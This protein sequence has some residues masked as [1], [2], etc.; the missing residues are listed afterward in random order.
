MLYYILQAALDLECNESHN[1][2]FFFFGLLWKL[3]FEI[4]NQ[5]LHADATSSLCELLSVYP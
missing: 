4:L 1:W 3:F 2:F 5:H